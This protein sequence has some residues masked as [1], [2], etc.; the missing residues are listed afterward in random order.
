MTNVDNEGGTRPCISPWEG[1]RGPDRII[2]GTYSRYALAA[3]WSR[4]ATDVQVEHTRLKGALY[5]RL[6]LGRRQ[7]A[8]PLE[9]RTVVE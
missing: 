2:K 6:S 1:L 5:A 4:R 9:D 3:T 8:H 7:G